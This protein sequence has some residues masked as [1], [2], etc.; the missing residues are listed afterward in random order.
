MRV[1]PSLFYQLFVIPGHSF[2]S[3]HLLVHAL[4]PNKI[5]KTNRALLQGVKSLDPSGNFTPELFNC[6]FEMTII[7]EIQRAFPSIS[8]GG[9]LFHLLQNIHNRV[10]ECGLQKEYERNPTINLHVR[11]IVAS[12]YLPKCDVVF[13]FKQLEDY[14]AESLR[15]M[16]DYYVEDNN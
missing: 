5:S 15:P 7:K 12:A 16:W 4:L 2:G 6:D 1:T 9:C 3:A 10:R 8:V 14:V 11:M 13:G